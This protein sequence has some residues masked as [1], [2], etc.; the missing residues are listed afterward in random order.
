[1]TLRCRFLWHQYGS[2]SC[3]CM[4]SVWKIGFTD[5]KCP[6]IWQP[7][8]SL[9][10]HY[11]LFSIY[12]FTLFPPKSLTCVTS[13]KKVT[14]LGSGCCCMS[15]LRSVSWMDVSSGAPQENFNKP[16]SITTVTNWLKKKQ[17]NQAKWLIHAQMKSMALCKTAVTP[18][19]QQN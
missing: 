9:H 11:T 12:V 16:G 7:A 13:R 6:L 2:P 1:M 8:L 10:N 15:C 19:H 3:Y 5:V 14:T 17:R 18:V 4:E